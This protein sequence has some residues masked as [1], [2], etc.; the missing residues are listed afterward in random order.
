MLLLLLLLLLLFCLGKELLTQLRR[1][2]VLTL[3][4]QRFSL[5]LVSQFIV[6]D[7]TAGS[8][9]RISTVQV[10]IKKDF[11]NIIHLISPHLS[12]SSFLSPSYASPLT[13]SLPSLSSYASIFSF[14]IY[15][16]LLSISSC[17][18]VFS[19]FIAFSF[20]PSYSFLFYL[21]NRAF[22]HGL[23]SADQIS[24]LSYPWVPPYLYYTL[25]LSLAVS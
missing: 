12:S 21:S 9:G 14:P 15:F 8:F 11:L 23:N 1:D 6:T 16:C 10:V 4:T 7:G 3:L 18:F 2:T 20:S 22:A 5:N 17:F 24:N 25:I 19:S 13:S